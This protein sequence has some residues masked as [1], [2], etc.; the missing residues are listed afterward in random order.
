MSSKTI[1]ALINIMYIIL[2]PT[3]NNKGIKNPILEYVSL[4]SSS[5][6]KKRKLRL[7][8][9]IISPVRIKTRFVVD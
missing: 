6:M 9:T 4:N 7:K 1:G 5:L 2:A 3:G 8:Q